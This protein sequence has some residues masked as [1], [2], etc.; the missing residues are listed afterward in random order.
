MLTLVMKNLYVSSQEVLPIKRS[1][2]VNVRAGKIECSYAE[3]NSRKDKAIL[4][5]CRA[6]LQTLAYQNW[7]PHI[8]SCLH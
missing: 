8:V 7:Q 2:R 1:T 4:P 6:G 5:D 3:M